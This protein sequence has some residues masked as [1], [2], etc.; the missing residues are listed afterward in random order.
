MKRSTKL[1]IILAFAVVLTLGRI[2][3][4]HTQIPDVQPEAAGGQLDAR[5]VDFS[6]SH[7]IALDGDWKQT[8][9][10]DNPLYTQL[11][12]YMQSEAAGTYEITIQTGEQADHYALSIRSL[13]SNFSVY[14]NDQLVYQTTDFENGP[15][16]P[17]AITDLRANE[18]DQLKIRLTFD[19]FHG[20]ERD[21]SLINVRFG[22]SQQIQKETYQA[23]LLQFFV[24]AIIFIHALYAFVLYLMKPKKIGT[25]FFSVAAILASLAVVTSDYNTL[26][27]VMPLSHEWYVRTIY[28]SYVGLS[29]FFLLFVVFTFTKA[30]SKWP[31]KVLYLLFTAYL[32]YIL[33]APIEIVRYVIGIAI[34]LVVA[35][36]LIFW[37]LFRTVFLSKERALPLFL[38]GAAVVS[39]VAWTIV[40]GNLPFLKDTLQAAIKA[41]FYPFDITIALVCFCSFWFL[42]FFQT[43]TENEQYIEQLEVEQKR[44]DQFLANTSHELRTPLHGMM[45]MVQNVL[46]Q[47]NKLTNQSRYQLELIHTL[48]RKMS[49]LINDLIDVNQLKSNKIRLEPS[50]ISIEPILVGTADMLRF[51]ADEK[52]VTIHMRLSESVPYIYADEHRVTQIVTNMLHNALKFTPAGNIT[53]EV[54]SDASHLYVKVID[55]GIGMDA[56]TQARIFIPYEKGENSIS[57]SEGIGLGLSISRQLA[58]LHGGSLTAESVLGEGS[59]FTLSLPL[60]ADRTELYKVKTMSLIESAASEQL[61]EPH[62]QA[63]SGY[64]ILAI[65]DDPVNLMVL[66]Q[67]LEADGYQISTTASATE[68]VHQ[69]DTYRWDLLIIDVMMPEISGFRLTKRIRSRYSLTELPVLLL[70]ARSQP[71]DVYAGF[72]AGANEYVSKPVD[73]LELKMRIKS[74]LELKSSIEDRLSMEAAWL[75]AQIHPH[76]LFNTLN[77]IGALSAI[78]NDRMLRLLQEFG[79]YLQA[80]FNGNNL[81]SSIPIEKEMDLVRSYLYIQKERFGERLQVNWEIDHNIQFSLPPLT[82]QPLVENAILHGLQP[83]ED[84][85]T[86]LIHLFRKGN[87]AFI[88]I[89]DDGI[90]IPPDKQR[91]LHPFD[92]HRNSIG[93]IN[94]HIRL[95][96]LNG[97][98]LILCSEE[99]LGTTIQISIPLG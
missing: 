41:G 64:R 57:E 27:Y 24:A 54:S 38:A 45:N 22:S 21:R 75:Q 3:W 2:I 88:Q 59:V 31:F 66:K 39:H 84:G 90:G 16:T 73:M 7:S 81:S 47:E 8:G 79:N 85:G 25:L 6:N 78:D 86:I 52:D 70:T 77:T 83:K 97:C 91:L 94:T 55:T 10:A 13:Y 49:Y 9:K 98:G 43:E 76:F 17:V 95:Q 15:P 74:L 67:A 60:D 33:A 32:I 42:R 18:N 12:K 87:N 4:Y 65:D 30:A 28:F 58:E 5:Q 34:S 29:F 62:I 82:L 80:S 71:E 37:I 26:G 1:V 53:I 46:E 23:G 51:M 56:K 19:E 11:P 69:L 89:K 63:F 99:G 61:S 35:F 72:Q 44:K 50:S 96:K 68:F 14:A 48:S 20:N 40:V 93:L 92:G 36:T